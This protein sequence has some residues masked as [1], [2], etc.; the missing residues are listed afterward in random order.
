[1]VVY[2][3]FLVPETKGLS[4]EYMGQLFEQRIVRA[5]FEPL[6][7]NNKESSD[8]KSKNSDEKETA[9]HIECV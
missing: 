2:A 5:P 4:L 7:I 3:W 1:M 9:T 6:V 8:M